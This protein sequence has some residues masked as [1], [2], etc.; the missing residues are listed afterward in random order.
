MRIVTTADVSML[1]TSLLRNASLRAVAL[2][3][4][5]TFVTHK[6]VFAQASA[7]LIGPQRYVRCN[8]VA[9]GRLGA[10]AALVGAAAAPSVGGTEVRPYM[11]LHLDRSSQLAC[12]CF[13]NLEARVDGVE[14]AQCLRCCHTRMGSVSSHSG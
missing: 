9:Y 4:I 5:A 14:L 12:T 13:G 11:L 2:S 8:D 7:L 6:L 10:R 3:S 1:F